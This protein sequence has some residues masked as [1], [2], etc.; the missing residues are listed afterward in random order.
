M[1]CINLPQKGLRHLGRRERTAVQL[2]RRL[3]AISRTALTTANF[4]GLFKLETQSFIGNEKYLNVIRVMLSLP[5]PAKVGSARPSF[6]RPLKLKT[7]NTNRY[8]L[9]L[10]LLKRILPLPPSP[11]SNAPPPFKLFPHPHPLPPS[12]QRFPPSLPLASTAD[13][14]SN[15]EEEKETCESEDEEGDDR[16]CCYDC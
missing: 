6:H 11:P 10:S 13:R 1:L 9:P 3:I 4:T 5:P 8:P 15:L 16:G 12:Q 2:Q 7:H 14:T